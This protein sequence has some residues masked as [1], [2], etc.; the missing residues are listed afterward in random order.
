MN[1]TV[2]KILVT[3]V[4][5]TIVVQTQAQIFDLLRPNISNI[6]NDSTGIWSLTIEDIM[7]IKV[8]SA[9]R[10]EES[11]FLSPLTSYVVTSNDIRISGANSIPE[12]LKQVPGII[13]R[14]SAPGAYDVSMRGMSIQPMQYTNQNTRTVLIMVDYRII[15]SNYDGA[16]DWSSLPVDMLDIDRIEIV[17]GP[18]GALYGPNACNGIIHI[19]TK[20][21]SHKAVVNAKAEAGFPGNTFNNLYLGSKISEKLSVGVSGNFVRTTR[22]VADY[23][24]VTSKTFIDDKDSLKPTAF[25]PAPAGPFKRERVSSEKFGA[26]VF[27]NYKIGEGELSFNGGYQQ[28]QN[29][30][31]AFTSATTITST[32]FSNYYSQIR[33]QNKNILAYVDINSGKKGYINNGDYTPGFTFDQRTTNAYIHYDFKLGNKFSIVP[34]LSAQNSYLNGLPYK[35]VFPDGTEYF[36]I[37]NST[38]NNFAPSLRLNYNPTEKWRFILAGRFDKFTFNN[39]WLPNLSAVANYKINENNIVRL[40]LGQGFSG[41]FGQRTDINALYGVVSLGGGANLY[42]KYVP[43]IQHGNQKFQNA[44][45]GYRGKIS[46]FISYDVVLFATKTQDIPN[47]LFVGDT[48]LGKGVFENRSRSI[49]NPDQ[50]S[51]QIGTSINLNISLLKNKMLIRPFVMYQQNNYFNAPTSF[52]VPNAPSIGLGFKPV[53]YH[54]Q[55]NKAN[56]KNIQDP[57]WIGGMSIDYAPTKKFGIYLAA[58]GYSGYSLFTNLDRPSNA[59]LSKGLAINSSINSNG[60]GAYIQSKLVFNAN[61]TYKITK[62]LSANLNLRNFTNNTNREFSRGDQIGAQYLVG[63]QFNY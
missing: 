31:M 51:E 29:M 26:N 21:V 47:F 13:V 2:K 8:V 56:F 61:I 23:Y 30:T 7:N 49:S 20:K 10:K 3:I 37:Q 1:K 40:S 62:Q 54:Y 25:T 35:S 57:N 5:F 59:D 58:N 27:V 39:R 9:S 53:A 4:F 60:V 22:N 28:G 17:E 16:F 42:L 45:V 19:S 33:Y 14:E 6:S 12:A 48:S 52:N 41:M 24:D 32:I 46:D 36:I 63:L 55:Q 11:S 34:A 43:N 50:Y 44:D 15:F 18:M 38:I